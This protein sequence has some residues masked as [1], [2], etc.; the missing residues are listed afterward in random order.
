MRTIL[1]AGAKTIGP[2]QAF[3]APKSLRTLQASVD[4][5]GSVS[6]T[7][8][9]EGTNDGVHFLPLGTVTLSGT[10]TATD[11]FVTDAPWDAVRANVTA[12]SAG[13]VVTAA[14]GWQV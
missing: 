12:I 3:A 2:G 8:V 4:G 1:L 10:D 9:F 6:A 14:E 11:G 13:G 5:T 7:V